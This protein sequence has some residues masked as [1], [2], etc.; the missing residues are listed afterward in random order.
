MCRLVKPDCT[1]LGISRAI[2]G[3]N[4]PIGKVAVFAPNIS[5]A[6]WDLSQRRQPDL[7]SITLHNDKQAQFQLFVAALSGDG[8]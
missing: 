3:S 7:H 4:S 8:R 1:I 5:P 6:R 2:A